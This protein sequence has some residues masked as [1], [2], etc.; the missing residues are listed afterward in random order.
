MNI[1]G[2]EKLQESIKL[3]D[4][5]PFEQIDMLLERWIGLT[6]ECDSN[7]LFNASFPS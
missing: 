6:R 4:T 7:Y 1:L 2:A 5:H 3:P